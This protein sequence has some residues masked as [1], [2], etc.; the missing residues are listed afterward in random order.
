MVIIAAT[1]L[2]S[3]DLGESGL[4]GVDSG[5]KGA[6]SIS[7]SCR[8]PFSTLCQ[9]LARPVNGREWQVSRSFNVKCSLV[10]SL[11]TCLKLK[12]TI[13]IRKNML[14]IEKKSRG[15]PDLNRGPIDLQSIALPLSYTPAADNIE[16][17]GEVNLNFTLVGRPKEYKYRTFGRKNV[18]IRPGT[19]TKAGQS[20]GRRSTEKISE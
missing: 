4:S 19:M 1:Y 6:V 14:K 3:H 15:H 11:L 5:V 9:R 12:E 17:R 10:V 8:R 13:A 20:E 16:N 2:E 18:P 7:D